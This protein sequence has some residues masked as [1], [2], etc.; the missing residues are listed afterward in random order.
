MRK[1]IGVFLL[2]GILATPP[3]F[4]YAHTQ[5]LE[6]VGSTQCTKLQYNLT[7]VYSFSK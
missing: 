5:P 3:S 1:V 7:Q 6:G 4:V 2:S